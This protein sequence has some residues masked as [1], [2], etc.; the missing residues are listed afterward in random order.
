MKEWRPIKNY[1]GFYEVSNNGLVRSVDRLVITKCRSRFYKGKNLVLSYDK[2]GYVVVFLSKMGVRKLKKIHRLVLEAFKTK[3]LGSRNQAN[4]INGVK[5]DNCISNLEWVTCSENMKHAHSIGLKNQKLENNNASKLKLV[6][7]EEIR[8]FLKDG[9]TQAEIASMYN[10]SKATVSNINT[11][12]VWV[13][14]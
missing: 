1:K 9:I 5:D 13:L 10:I 11:D 14:K 2:D 6:D 3:H 4:H 12:K 8:V 7:V